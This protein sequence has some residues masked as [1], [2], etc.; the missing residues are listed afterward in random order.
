MAGLIISAI[1]FAAIAWYLRTREKTTEETVISDDRAYWEE[2]NFWDTGSS[3]YGFGL[4][5]TSSDVGGMPMLT[6]MLT[7]I[8]Y[9]HLGCNIYHN[10]FDSSLDDNS[11]LSSDDDDS[12]SDDDCW[13]SCSNDD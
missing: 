9:A 13:S 2:E 4:G 8:T 5:I 3:A 6:S 7:D 1:I 10:M 11:W 12:F